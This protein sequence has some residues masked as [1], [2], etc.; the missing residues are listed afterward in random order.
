MSTKEMTMKKGILVLALLLPLFAQAQDLTKRAEVVATIEQL[1]DG[2][3]AADSAQVRA[4]FHPDMRLQTTYID[5]EGNPQIVTGDIESFISSIGSSEPGTLNEKIWRYDVQISQNLASVWTPY[6]FFV[7][8]KLSH[9]GVNT[10][11]LFRGENGW[12][13]IQI[14][15]T[16]EREGC[17]TEPAD[18]QKKLDLFI[19]NWHQAAADADA[20]AF[21]G[22]MAEDGIYI[23]TDK[24]ER[25]LRDELREWAA[26]AF[27]RDTAWDFT[28][29]D[30]VITIAPDE[31][32]AWWDETLDTWM[33]VCR[34]TG[35]LARTPNGWAIKHYQLSLTVPN[36]KIEA[37]KELVR[38]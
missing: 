3:R 15:D 34:S 14:A 11:Q 33:G 35:I 24:S 6:T 26:D 36:E 23:G 7:G 29:I 1:F 20:D 22:A 16:R 17:P 13:I 18:L 5:E 8:D 12:Q 19:E 9:C 37:F 32:H 21:F 2:M 27:E 31:R 38:E 25:W 10:F 4:V 30:R 28:T